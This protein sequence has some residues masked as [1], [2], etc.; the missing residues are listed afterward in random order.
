MKKTLVENI[1]PA[2]YTSK[3]KYGSLKYETTTMFKITFR[4]VENV[5]NLHFS[6]PIHTFVR[7]SYEEVLSKIKELSLISFLVHNIQ[8]HSLII[9]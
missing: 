9:F 5:I 2:Q 6:S 1:L 7:D 8:E 4:E 3:R